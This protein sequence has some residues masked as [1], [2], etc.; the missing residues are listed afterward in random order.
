MPVIMPP[1]AQAKIL[2]RATLTPREAAVTSSSN[3]ERNASTVFD[4]SKRHSRNVRIAIM[5]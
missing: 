3:T 5:L 4:F 2:T 1:K